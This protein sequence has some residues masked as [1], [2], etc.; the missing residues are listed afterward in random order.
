[1]SDSRLPNIRTA[2]IDQQDLCVLCLVDS[3]WRWVERSRD[4][5]VTDVIV[6]QNGLSLC[7]ETGFLEAVGLSALSFCRCS[8][9]S[10]AACYSCTPRPV[11]IASSSGLGG[12]RLQSPFSSA[13]CVS[14]VASSS[15][16]HRRREPHGCSPDGRPAWHKPAAS[17]SP[18]SRSSLFILAFSRRKN[19]SPAGRPR[20]FLLAR[21]SQRRTRPWSSQERRTALPTDV[22]LGLGVN[23]LEPE[24]TG[25]PGL[26]GSGAARRLC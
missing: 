4:Q 8:M 5:L 16:C 12:D 2:I 24:A 1:M 3:R 19:W 22:L 6:L 14:S 17:M 26:P 21:E 9:P 23:L 15:R 10:C 7:E 25:T 18:E 13:C 20:A 11:P